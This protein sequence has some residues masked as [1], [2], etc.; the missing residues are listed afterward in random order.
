[1]RKPEGEWRP[2]EA[3]N[4]SKV[5]KETNGDG[6]QK[7]EWTKQDLKMTPMNRSRRSTWEID[8][9]KSF[10]LSTPVRNTPV[11]RKLRSVQESDETVK[12]K[13]DTETNLEVYNSTVGKP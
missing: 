9:K 6:G 7:D 4:V 2:L 3:A 5:K 10:G 8:T 13:N 1:M 12:E 11:E